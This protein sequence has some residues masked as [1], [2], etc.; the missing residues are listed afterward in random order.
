MKLE[1]VKIRNFRSIRSLDFKIDSRGLTLISG[2]NGQGKSSIYSAILYALFNKTQKGQTADAIINDVTKKDT[3]VILSYENAG[4]KYRVE[5]YRKHKDN[6]NKVLFYVNGVEKTSS[7]NKLT[8][9]LIEDSVGMSFDTMLN[10]FVLGDSLVTSF[11]KSTDKQRK[12]I[13]EDITNISIYKQASSVASDKYKEAKEVLDSTGRT[14]SNLEI[15]V[16]SLN[17]Q[18]ELEKSQ[19]KQREENISYAKQSY[20]ASLKEYEDLNKSFEDSKRETSEVPD[21]IDN[22]KA[23]L[24]SL[25]EEQR[26]LEKPRDTYAIQSKIN[27]VLQ[28]KNTSIE[29]ANRNKADLDKYGEQYK[30][31]KDAKQATCLYCG[32]PL[33]A[34]HK[35]KELKRLAD[36]GRKCVALIDK[37]KGLYEEA[38][39]SYSN[40]ETELNKI[41]EYNQQLQPKTIELNNKINDTVAKINELDRKLESTKLAYSKAESYKSTVSKYKDDLKRLEDS[42]SVDMSG[43]L[44]S[45]ESANNSLKEYSDKFDKATRDVKVLD[46]VKSVF[47]NTGIKSFVLEQVYPALN[48]SLEK[49]MSILTD[50]SISAS[51]MATSESKTGN[52]SDKI[53]I[54]VIRNSKETDYDSLSSGEQRRFDVALSLSLQDYVSANSGIN[55]LFLDEIF[56]SL[57]AVGV[58]KVM[59]LLKE[60]AKYYSSV[61]VISHSTELKDNFDNEIK[62][63]LTDKGTTIE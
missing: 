31:I 44:E 45:L 3:A 12:E 63:V 37:E 24:N 29:R 32:A 36:E 51:I 35:E 14:K 53:T 11:S 8:D 48:E 56:D 1:N 2:K 47:S 55:V 10:S 16:A 59:G 28:Q 40:L 22:L 54:N 30:S 46:G 57:D 18:L 26:S 27:S 25:K 9:S 43:T 23:T 33:N 39:S 34:E 13:I 49:Y 60:K 4:V 19:E 17:K 21:K 62:V 58:D 6:H 61:F 15:E 7:S 52:V 20:E 42:T 41:N 5:R 38:N 50:G